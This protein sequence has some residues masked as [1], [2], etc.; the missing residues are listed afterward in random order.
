MARG[1]A[2][3]A[4]LLLSAAGRL[5]PSA[6][7]AQPLRAKSTDLQV[8]QAARLNAM[9][10]MAA[11]L[12]HELSQPLA[13]IRNYA[14]AA[15]RMVSHNPGDP[16]LP[17]LLRKVSDQSERTARIVAR[18][19]QGADRTE[20]STTAQALPDLFAEVIDVAMA[21]VAKESVV[22]R[23]EFEPDAEQV[24]VD[25]VQVQQ[26]LLNLLR[27][28]L[29][30]MA[31]SGWRELRIGAGSEGPDHVRV[32]VIDSGAGIARDLAD[33]L[34]E[35]FVTDKIN[36]MGVGLSISRTIVEA[37]GGRIWAQ[38]APGGGAAFYF[39]LQRAPT[40]RTSPQT[41]APS[42]ARPSLR[43]ATP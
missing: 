26:V 41:A 38:R 5:N 6:A 20:L 43:P 28:A 1:L 17:D 12:A 32:H 4:N 39:T 31:D 18:I 33:Q 19:R 29:E 15:Q 25:R 9:G 42:R 13:A 40:P 23:Y 21:D 35:P 7:A 34:F 11:T 14:A 24:L 10:E 37:H 16:E 22:L 30:A 3:L 36:G 27:N 2:K 8:A